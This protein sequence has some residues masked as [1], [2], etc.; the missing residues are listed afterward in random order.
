VKALTITQIAVLRSFRGTGMYVGKDALWQ[1]RW[2]KKGIRFKTLMALRK[3]G[4]LEHAIANRW[5][6]TEQGR[7]FVYRGIQ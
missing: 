5:Y 2:P 1:H 6:L 4:Y 7:E 3:K